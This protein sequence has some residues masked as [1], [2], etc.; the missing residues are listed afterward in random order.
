L[1]DL[2][3][4]NRLQHH[5]GHVLGGGRR[6]DPAPTLGQP[7]A[8]ARFT[9]VIEDIRIWTD[10]GS[11]PAGELRDMVVDLR[12][13]W[14]VARRRIPR[15]RPNR[16]ARQ[17][18]RCR[19][20]RLLRAGRRLRYHPPLPAE[21]AYLRRARRLVDE[22]CAV[23]QR[24]IVPG[25]SVGPVYGEMMSTIRRGDGDPSASRWLMGA[26]EEASMSLLSVLGIILSARSCERGA[27]RDRC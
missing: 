10:Q 26:G 19:V 23:S 6:A 21:L 17:D 27:W 25:A 3:R 9:S 8:G 1:T 20:H 16:A 22:A 13:P 4:H 7:A 12:R 18:G 11:A 5:P 24:L 15:L 2:L 14:K